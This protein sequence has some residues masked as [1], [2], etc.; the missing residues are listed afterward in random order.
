MSEIVELLVGLLSAL[1]L[2]LDSQHRTG[3]IS[4]WRITLTVAIACPAGVLAA[5]PERLR[6]GALAGTWLF[7][8]V[9]LAVLGLVWFFI[10]RP[11]DPVHALLGKGVHLLHENHAQE[12]LTTFNQALDHAKSRREKG[13]ILFYMAAC[14]LRLRDK[15]LAVRTLAEALRVLPSVVARIAKEKDLAEIY[16]EVHPSVAVAHS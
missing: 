15:E 12:A 7:L 5:G 4:Y 9:Y 2:A 16:G 8:A 14:E 6:S 10:V 13:W 3:R 11:K 1:V